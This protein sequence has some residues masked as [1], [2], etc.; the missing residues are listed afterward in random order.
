MIR[1]DHLV[2]D[3]EEAIVT[4]PKEQRNMAAVYR[5]QIPNAIFLSQVHTERT[6]NRIKMLKGDPKDRDASRRAITSARW[7]A[8]PMMANRLKHALD[9]K[10]HLQHCRQDQKGAS[11]ERFAVQEAL[12]PGHRT[13]PDPNGQVDDIV[14]REDP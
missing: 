9:A 2:A 4:S 7:A 14:Y 3:V 5:M 6:H 13:E 8:S 1:L 12:P 10:T 11:S